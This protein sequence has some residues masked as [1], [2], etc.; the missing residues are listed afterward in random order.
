MRRIYDPDRPDSELTDSSASSASRSTAAEARR[1]SSRTRQA[2]D[3]ELKCSMVHRSEL[4]SWQSN[5][6]AT[7]LTTKLV[8]CLPKLAQRHSLDLHVRRLD[9]L[10]PFGRVLAQIL[11]KGVEPARY[12]LHRKA[13]EIFFLEFGI[14]D[15]PLH[16]GVDLLDDV[17]GRARR[18]KQPERY[19]RLVSRNGLGDGRDV[20]K[21]RQALLATESEHL[22][23]SVL[24]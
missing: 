16:V 1:C 20:G 9:D 13:F 11:G 2:K 15:D 24:H 17:R 19:A 18:G 8:P 22:E 12:R 23:L 4:N 5:D 10:A 7:S 6:P 14:A 21:R 3:T